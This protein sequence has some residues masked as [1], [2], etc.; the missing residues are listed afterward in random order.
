MC[1]DKDNGFQPQCLYEV[2]KRKKPN[3]TRQARLKAGAQRTLAAVAC[4][5]LFGKAPRHV[6]GPPVCPAHLLDHLIRQEEQ[7]WRHRDPQCLGGLEVDDELELHGLLHGQVGGLGPFEDLVH[8]GGR[9]APH[10]R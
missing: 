6:C 9:T 5:R 3:A 4:T 8:I 1:L 7:R 10:V 2:R